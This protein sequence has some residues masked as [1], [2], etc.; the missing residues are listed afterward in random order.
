MVSYNTVFRIDFLSIKK[1]CKIHDFFDGQSQ[2]LVL[3]ESMIHNKLNHPAIIKFKGINFVSYED[4]TKFQPTILMEYCKNGTLRNLMYKEKR[5]VADSEW[6]PTKK[7]IC[8]LGIAHAM[9]YLHKNGVIHRDLKIDNVLL[10]DNLYPKLYDFG[11]SRIFEQSLDNCTLLEMT[12]QVGT[13]LYMAPELIECEEKYGAGV[14]VY[15]FGIILYELITGL[16]PYSEL[17]DHISPFK[18]LKK[19]NEG[20]RPQ[21]PKDIR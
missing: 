20:Y 21:I 7:Y 16:I 14:D 3:R 1:C 19:V 12:T 8:L 13:P 9:K 4:P 15:A 11:L 18:L 2:K 17:E 5:S 6:T 10:D